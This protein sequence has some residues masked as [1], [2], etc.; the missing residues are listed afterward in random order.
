MCGTRAVK[1]KWSRIR[2]HCEAAAALS[3]SEGESAPSAE[4]SP[5]RSSGLC[6]DCCAYC[7]TT[8][9]LE[10]AFRLVLQLII[11]YLGIT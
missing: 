9:K 11:T 10:L 7:I 2:D 1:E 6:V 4:D 3:I 5:P 8:H